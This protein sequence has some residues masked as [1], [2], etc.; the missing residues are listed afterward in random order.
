M[1]AACQRLICDLRDRIASMEGV[2][3]KQAGTLSFGVT[4]SMR[5][6]LVVVLPMERCMSSQAVAQALLMVLPLLFVWP[7]SSREP[8]V[9]SSGVCREFEEGSTK[10]NVTRFWLGA[11]HDP[12]RQSLGI[13]YLLQTLKRKPALP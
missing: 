5:C 12:S 4:R 6:C 10:C 3:A 1:T 7:A 8:K 13:Q 9:P 2:S 11:G